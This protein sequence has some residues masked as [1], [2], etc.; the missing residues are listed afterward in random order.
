MASLSSVINNVIN[1]VLQAC[2]SSMAQAR[3]QPA[4][5]RIACLFGI[6]IPAQL[7]RRN[8]EWKPTH[9]CWWCAG[10]V[11]LER[12]L[13]S[14]GAPLANGHVSSSRPVAPS[15]QPPAAAKRAGF[16]DPKAK[17]AAGRVGAK[18]VK[19]PAAEM[20]QRQLAQ[21]AEVAAKLVCL[22]L[23]MS[24]KAFVAAR[25]NCIN[26]SPTMLPIYP[27]ICITNAAVH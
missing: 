14:V 4:V 8:M 15:K 27:C 21:E 13:S 2:L 26:R 24:L 25:P 6:C 1:Q 11:A 16:A 22:S 20:R 9:Q 7:A 12:D 23:G 18:A 5:A 3:L 19:D 10:E 17:A